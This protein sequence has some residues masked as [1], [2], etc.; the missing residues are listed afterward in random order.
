MIFKKT[1]I[2]DCVEIDLDK[3][4]DERGFFARFFCQDEFK[5]FNLNNKILQINTSLTKKAGTLRGLHYQKFP[6]QETKV[7]RCLKGSIYD[8]VVDLRKKSKTYLKYHAV[9]LNEVNRKMLYV[10]KGCAHGFLSLK[11]NSEVIYLVSN[12]YNPKSEAGLNYKDPKIKIKWP[13]KIKNI[14]EKD[15]SW[16]YLQ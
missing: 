9:T 6:F 2:K 4:E 16:N 3:K 13:I 12:M 5:K 8:V 10:P 15:D 14:T 11:N 7:V 1:K